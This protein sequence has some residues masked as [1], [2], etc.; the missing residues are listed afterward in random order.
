MCLVNCNVTYKILHFSGSFETHEYCFPEL[1]ALDSTVFASTYIA[2]IYDG[3]AYYM[4]QSSSQTIL[5]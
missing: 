2:A 4:P 3:N 1:R 5:W